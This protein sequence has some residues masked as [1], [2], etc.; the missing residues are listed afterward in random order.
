M[1]R[2]VAPRLA[3]IVVRTSTIRQLFRDMIVRGPLSVVRGQ[4][5]RTTDHGPR[6]TDYFFAFSIAIALT[7]GQLTLPLPRM[8]SSATWKKS[9]SDGTHRFGMPQLPSCC[10]S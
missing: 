3:A 8:G 1:T 4:L 5:Q 9:R 7:C 10:Q 6:T 2:A